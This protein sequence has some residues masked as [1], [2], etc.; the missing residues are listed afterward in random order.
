MGSA[1]GRELQASQP[2]WVHPPPSPSAEGRSPRRPRP[3]PPVKTGLMTQAGPPLSSHIQQRRLELEPL[4]DRLGQLGEGEVG[5]ESHCLCQGDRVGPEPLTHLQ[6]V[7][8][9]SPGPVCWLSASHR[10]LCPLVY[11]PSSLLSLWEGLAAGL[12]VLG[13]PTCGAGNRSHPRSPGSCQLTAS[14]ESGAPD[15]QPGVE[16]ASC[17]CPPLSRLPPNLPVTSFL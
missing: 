4:W 17:K 1:L 2:S 6:P 3:R 12:G 15:V 7:L 9:R 5:G 14:W 16:N 8:A 13:A 10:A 11:V